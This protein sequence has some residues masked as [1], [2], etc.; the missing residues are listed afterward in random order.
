[1]NKNSLKVLKYLYKYSNYYTF[2]DRSE[3]MTACHISDIN[4]IT[5][6]LNYLLSKNYI[7]FNLNND[8]SK[9]VRGNREY[10]CSLIGKD[11]FKEQYSKFLVIFIVPIAIAVISS[12]I[13][14]KIVDNNT[15]NNYNYNYCYDSNSNT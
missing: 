5:D 9:S 2:F 4:E 13:T 14:S 10:F 6:I 1:M 12:I 15:T 7:S 11:Y 3:L 8:S